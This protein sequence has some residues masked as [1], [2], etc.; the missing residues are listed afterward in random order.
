MAVCICDWLHFSTTTVSIY[1]K[2]L[3]DNR[4]KSYD[5]PNLHRHS[6][7]TFELHDILWASIGN[8][9]QNVCPSEFAR[10]FLVDF[11]VSPQV[12]GLM[13]RSRG[14]GMAVCICDG[15]HFST[16]T[17]ST[18]HKNISNNQVESYGHP[19]LRWHSISTFELS[20][21]L[22]GSIGHPSQNFRV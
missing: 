3:S 9:S 21:I 5:R 11:L 20:D 15:H 8:L 6:I 17:I 4:V 2:N 10:V 16:T 1:H 13:R 14:K 18:Y 7:S 22:L 12:S 19:N